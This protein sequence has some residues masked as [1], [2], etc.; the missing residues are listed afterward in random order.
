MS[1]PEERP[2]REPAKPATKPL[3]VMPPLMARTPAAGDAALFDAVEHA[4]RDR[5]TKDTVVQGHGHR[6]YRDVNAPGAVLIGLD[7]ILADFGSDKILRAVRPL[8]WGRDGVRE[9]SWHG[10][11]EGEP[12]RLEAKPGYIVGAIKGRCG[13]AMVGVQLVF[14]RTVDGRI[15][16]EDQYESTYAGGEGG[17]AFEPFAGDGSPIVGLIGKEAVEPEDDFCGLGAVIGP[18]MRKPPPPPTQRPAP[19][20]GELALLKRVEAA[21]KQKRTVDTDQLA[22]GRDKYRDVPEPGAV[23]VGLD[24][25]LAKFVDSDIIGSIRPLY[26]SRDGVQEGAW[27]GYDDRSFIRLEAKPGYVVGGLK[28]NSGLGI[29]SLQV[30]FMRVADGRLNPRDQY[31]SRR[32]GGDGGGENPPLA[33]DGSIVVGLHGQCSDDRR[34]GVSGLGLVVVPVK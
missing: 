2:A 33:G 23:L 17:G 21:V 5:S 34:D 30:V 4:V 12:I 8:F 11:A 32:V 3:P 27:H 25:G 1:E 28:I 29:C 16:R 19:N 9:G 18:Q 20:P 22:R 6:E 13:L 7:V 31:E 10:R 14:M 15:D 26:W 24:I